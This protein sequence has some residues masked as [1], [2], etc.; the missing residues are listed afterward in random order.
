MV[1]PKKIVWTL[2]AI[3]VRTLARAGARTWDLSDSIDSLGFIALDLLISTLDN[4]LKQNFKEL[5][6]AVIL[7]LKNTSYIQ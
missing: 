6:S 4:F 1:S 7:S 2:A 3:E 5:Y